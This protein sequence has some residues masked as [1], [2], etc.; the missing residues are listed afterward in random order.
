MN[1]TELITALEEVK[2]QVGPESQV[3]IISE[4][5]PLVVMQVMYPAIM[6]DKALHRYKLVSLGFALSKSV[7][8]FQT[9]EVAEP[10]S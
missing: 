2:D 7:S 1:I 8:G 6:T 5:D 9:K 4:S 10:K 3:I